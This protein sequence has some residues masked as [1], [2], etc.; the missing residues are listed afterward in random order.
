MDE[1][2]QFIIE[3]LESVIEGNQEEISMVKEMGTA[4][5]AMM[6]GVKEADVEAHISKLNGTI[7][8]L[9]IALNIVHEAENGIF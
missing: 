7:H 8:G 6:E 5:A 1:K 4:E 9:K 2:T 3:T